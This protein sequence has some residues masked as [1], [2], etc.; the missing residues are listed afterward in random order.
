MEGKKD[1][2]KKRTFKGMSKAVSLASKL[3]PKSQRKKETGPKIAEFKVGIFL[4]FKFAYTETLLYRAR[5]GKKEV[6]V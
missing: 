3:S 6:P 2:E 1:L 4:N 5:I